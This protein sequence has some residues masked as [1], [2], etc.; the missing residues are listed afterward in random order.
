M[1]VIDEVNQ[2]HLVGKVS[3]LDFK[4]SF[5]PAQGQE[6][7][8]IWNGHIGNLALF[9]KIRE[10][11]NP[12]ICVSVWGDMYYLNEASDEFPLEIKTRSKTFWLNS[13]FNISKE[14]WIERLR[15]VDLI[16]NVLV[17]IPSRRPRQVLGMKS[18]KR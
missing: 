16:E 2:N 11:R 8:I 12:H 18:G 3:Q 4:E 1:Y 10:G 15:R 7:K 6:S 5:R 14:I 17:E 13:T 9:E